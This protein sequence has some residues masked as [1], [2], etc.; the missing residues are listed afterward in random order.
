MTEALATA[1]RMLEHTGA[2]LVVSLFMDLD[3][4]RFATRP[5]RATQLRSLLDEAERVQ[6]GDTSLGHQDRAALAVDLERLQTY[7]E[8]GDPPLSG[9]RSLAVFCS[10]R[11]ELFESVRLADPAEPKVVVARTPYVEPLVAGPA[12]GR[13]GVAL[14]NR[15][16]A[17]IMTVERDHVL[18]EEKVADPVRGRHHQGGWSQANYQRSVDHDADQH[19]RHVAGELYRT[20]QREPFARLVLGGPK[21]DVDRFAELLHNDL[22]PTLVSIRLTLDAETARVPDVRSALLPIIDD[23]RAAARAAAVSELQDLVQR[24]GAVAVGLDDT[25]HALAERRVGR[26]V[27]HRNF[28]AQGGRCPSCGLLY[29]QWPGTCPADGS[30]LEPVAD[31]REGAVEAAVLQDAEVIVVG[32]GSETPPEVLLRGGGIGAALRF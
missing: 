18:E 8:S 2:H 15:R 5:A 4:A 6:R 10:G 28:A 3:P 16:A 7:L 20:W 26:L 9:A 22:R 27:L 30:E 13:W 32:E 11:D 24:G 29:V 19:L 25:L 21:E 31:M 14:V 1:R 17:Q 12:V 23:E